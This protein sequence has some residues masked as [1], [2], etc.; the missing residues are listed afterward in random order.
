LGA[1]NGTAQELRLKIEPEPLLCR[2][3]FS[4]LQLSQSQYRFA[5]VEAEHDR[6]K[7]GIQEAEWVSDALSQR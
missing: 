6:E 7:Q 1:Q 3:C 2:E 4:R 5:A